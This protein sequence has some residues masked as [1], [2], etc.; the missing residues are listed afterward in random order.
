MIIWW[1]TSAHDTIL[2]TLA[3][4]V[5]TLKFLYRFV[6]PKTFY[7]QSVSII[8]AAFVLSLTLFII[9]LGWGLFIAPPD[10]QQGDAFRIIYLHVPAAFLSLATYGVMSFLAILLLVWRIKLAAIV[11]KSAL[12]FGFL[13]TLLTL[14]TGSLWGKPMWGTWWIWDA[15]LTSELLLRFIYLGLMAVT[16]TLRPASRAHRAL[17]VMT[18]V[19]VIDLPIIHYSV[20]W[21]STLHQGASLSLMAKPKIALPMLYPLLVML[22]AYVSF[23]IGV[24]LMRSRYELLWSERSQRWVQKAI[25]DY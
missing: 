25:G 16:N 22:A 19:G 24:V 10:Y 3:L 9:A 5:I 2:S 13:M 15:R 6:S 11:L 7:Y 1:R 18:L 4:V 17:A 20:S 21:W 12:S 14:L 8:Y 23:G